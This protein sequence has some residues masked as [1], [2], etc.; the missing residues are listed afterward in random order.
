MTNADLIVEM[1]RRAGIRRAFGVPSG[2]VLP[3]IEAMRG[4][5]IDYILTA[6]ETTAGYMAAVTG[7]LTG[8]PGVCISTLGPGATNMATGVGGAW[9]DR[10][11]LIAITCNVATPWLNR[12]IQMRIDHQ[13]L[14]QP[15]TKASFAMRQGSVAS[16]LAAA[17]AIAADEPPGPVHV[18]LPEDVAVAEA[19]E[20]PS[21]FAPRPVLLDHSAEAMSQISAALSRC[22]RPIVVTGLTF[23]RSAE[24]AALLRFI[25]KQSVPFV[26][27]AHAKGFLPESHPNWAGV[28]GRARRTNVQRL[29]DRADLV[30]AVGY[31]P[32]EINYEEW[33]GELQIVHLSTEAAESGDG[34]SFVFNKAADMD[35]AI[36]KLPHLPAEKNDW[37]QAELSAHVNRSSWRCDRAQRVPPALRNRRG[38]RCT[39]PSMSCG[40][41]CLQ[42][43]SSHMTSAPITTRLR[44]NGGPIS[45][46]T[47]SP[48]MAGRRWGSQCPPPTPRS[49]SIQSV[50]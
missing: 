8:V 43:A 11:P 28:L 2:P 10:A 15:I 19:T 17:L 38:C 12:R 4:G 29:I 44:V 7:Q 22:R 42:T 33:I 40:S 14:F 45:R 41:T 48:P 35:A 21:T 9:L 34:L 6:S 36:A 47:A 25:E 37:D 5:G 31:D 24:A 46:G 18:D 20:K 23:T 3:L 13:T 39:P 1:L 32:V 26:T 27:T 49:L 50:Q 16:T 30:I